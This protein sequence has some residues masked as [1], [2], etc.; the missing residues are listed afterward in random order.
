MKTLSL[1]LAAVPLR[2]VLNL[3]Q[4]GTT[5]FFSREK[6]S[7]PKKV[8]VVGAGLAG[9]TAA[10]ELSQAGHEV[11]ILEARHRAGGRVFTVREFADT[12]YAECG[13]EWVEHNHDYMM[14]YIEEF[15][16]SLY[17]GS[18]RDTEDEGLQFS[19]RARQP[20]EKLRNL[21]TQI[22]PF[23]H[24]KPSLPT[25]DKLSFYEL[26]KQLDAPPDMIAQMQRSI[27][28]LM[29][30][31]IE[32][33]SAL[34]VLNEFALP[35]SR[36]SFRIAGGNDQVPKALATHLR[37]RMYYARPVVRIVHDAA[38]VHITFLENGLQQTLRAERIVLAVPFTCLRK[39]EFTP[40]LSLEKM[41]AI[42]TLGY[43]QILKAPLQ[44]RERFWLKQMNEP[45]KS[46]SGLMGS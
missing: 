39:I 3:S 14:R 41:K 36:A 21:T 35:E 29:A 1:A 19:P 42:T 26:L 10:Y 45:R 28:S 44:F 40:A 33:I 9:L 15:G 34:H 46:L 37:N 20:H 7:R 11:T 18:F 12:L 31:N 8:I 25:Y 43:G 16:L 22:N 17:R 5:Q 24:Q 38:E 23:E 13:G 27:S 32:S 6:T 30:I 4:V 2:P